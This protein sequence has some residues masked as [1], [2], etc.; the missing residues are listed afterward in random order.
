MRRRRRGRHDRASAPKSSSPSSRTSPESVSPARRRNSPSVDLPEPLARRAGDLAARDIEREHR[1]V[2]PKAACRDLGR[3]SI[4]PPSR[5]DFVTPRSRRSGPSLRPQAGDDDARP[6]AE[7]GGISPA[8]GSI[9]RGQRGENRRPAG[10]RLETRRCAL[11]PRRAGRRAPLRLS[12][13]A[14]PRAA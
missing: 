12:T 9:A 2:A 14:R 5:K 7:K 4:T 11:D 1:R 6:R 3:R 10:M 13:Q 8:Q